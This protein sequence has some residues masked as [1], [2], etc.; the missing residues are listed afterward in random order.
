M[1]FEWEG[2]AG[3]KVARA[4]LFRYR[5][6]VEEVRGLNVVARG[7]PCAIGE[8]CAIGAP[9]GVIPAEVVGFLPGHRV[10]LMPYGELAGLTAATGVMSSGRPP[11]IP[12]GRELLGRI[13]DGLGRPVDGGPPPAGPRRMLTPE[14][15]SPLDRLPLEQRLDTG[16]R[17]IDVLLTLGRGQRMG[18]FAGAGVG[19]TTLL[20]M[21][22]AGCSADVVVAALVGERGR[23]VAQF[24]GEMDRATRMRTVVVAATSDTPALMRLRAAEAAVTVAEAFRAQGLDVLLVMDSL[25]RVAM[26][27]REVG[28]Q[29]GEMASVRGYTPSVF[30]LLPRLL[31]RAGRTRTGSITG[32]YTVL[33][34]SDDPADPVG[35]TV[36]GILDGAI[37]LSRELAEE[38]HFPAVDV[39]RSLSRVMGDVVDAETWELAARVRHTLTTLEKSRDLVALGAYQPGS[40]R[41]IDRALALSGGMRAWLDQKVGERDDPDVAKRR[42]MRLMNEVQPDQ[43]EDRHAF[44]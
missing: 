43:E 3:A 23:E 1:A 20:H 22:M 41:E 11:T 32:F 18:I 30:H 44:A 16:V 4:R 8:L 37:Y 21:L 26:A 35:D 15:G 27:Q 9:G 25:T 2:E 33:L 29:S 14:P 34:D 17:V 6:H 39:A 10:F 31:E 19:K 24:W 12:V 40:D 36:R 38:H 28:L 7:L 13:V 5:G 42:L